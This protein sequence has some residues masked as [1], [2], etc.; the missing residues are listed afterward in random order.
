MTEEFLLFFHVCRKIGKDRFIDLL[1]Q[2]SSWLREIHER[3]SH[4]R[5]IGYKLEGFSPLCRYN[6]GEEIKVDPGKSVQ[7]YFEC[8]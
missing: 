6:F 5:M 1:L 8:L 3:T 2:K 4:K 7:R